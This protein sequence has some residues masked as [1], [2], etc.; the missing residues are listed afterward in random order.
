MF[1]WEVRDHRDARHAHFLG[2]V[3]CSFALPVDGRAMPTFREFMRVAE[4]TAKDKT[5]GTR[6]WEIRDV[7]KRHDAFRGLTPEKA[8]AILED[9]G[10]TYVKMGQIASNRSDILPKEYCDAFKALRADV[11]PLAFDEVLAS[12]ERSYGASWNRV[13]SCIEQEPLGSASVAQVHKAVLLDGSVVAVKVRRPG[14]VR[15]M[16]EDIMLMKHLLALAEFSLPKQKE[17]FVLTLDGLVSELERTTANELDFMVELGNLMHFAQVVRNQRGV[18]S[19]KPYA[20]FTTEDVLVMEFVAGTMI[21][22]A[23]A[24][25]EQGIDAEELGSRLVQSYVSQVVDAGFFHADPHPGNIVVRNG[26][27]VWI[28]L[29]MMGTLSAAERALVG[30]A[31]FAVAS[32]D[33]YALKDVLLGLSVA[34]GPV[35]H[36]F[37]LDQVNSLL[38]SYGKAGLSDIN[39]GKALVDVVEV[40]R[41]QNLSPPPSFTMLARGLLTL[42]GVLADLSPNVSV[43]GI[44][45]KRVRR[46]AMS[47]ESIKRKAR[48]V[49][50]SAAASAE[51]SARLPSQLSRTFDML[52]KGQ[53]KASVELGVPEEAMATLYS[54]GG[55]ISLSMISAGLFVGS[56]ILCTTDMQPR[57]LE[58]PLMGALGYVGAFVL[59]VYVVWRTMVVRHRQRNGEKME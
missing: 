19:P 51:A 55:R 25:A 59:G 57:I 34:R 5:S 8:V 13:F 4:V 53:L 42:E 36:G 35:D 46:Q 11:P 27:I 15:Q 56:S 47:W 48:D 24:L 29:G 37:L 52:D 12:I 54:L 7:L 40:L 16:A 44:A 45:A 26:E 18:E 50:A 38:V 10:P 3:R 49:A 2:V 33:A 28:D 41:S 20:S 9:L 14:V 58:V 22:D 31:F 30:E 23:K 43:A 17:G 39:M 6:M 1:P 32:G 21:G